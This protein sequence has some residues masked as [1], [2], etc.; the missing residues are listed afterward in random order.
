VLNWL[1]WRAAPARRGVRTAAAAA[2][3][4]PARPVAGADQLALLPKPSGMVGRGM[5][6]HGIVGRGMVGQGLVGHGATDQGATA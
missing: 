5:V 1:N 2:P 6:G 4:G 3:P